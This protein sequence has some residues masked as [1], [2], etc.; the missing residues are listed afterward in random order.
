[1]P[2]AKEIA[3]RMLRRSIGTVIADICLDFGITPDT[4][5]GVTCLWP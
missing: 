4:R 2:T 5:C 3:A 1:V